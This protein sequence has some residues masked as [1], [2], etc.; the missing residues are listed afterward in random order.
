MLIR[1]M[2]RDIGKNKVQFAAIFLMM[3][4][5][6]FLFS[7]ISGEWNGMQSHFERYIEEQNLAD[8]WAYGESFTEQD[9]QKL[10]EDRR[11]HNIEG[12]MLLPMVPSGSEGVSLDC[13]ITEDNKISQMYV[14]Q[15]SSFDSA[16]EGIWLDELFAGENDYKHGD[17]I[18]LQ[19]KGMNIKGKILGLVY[20]PEY[21]YGASE[22]AMMP[23]HKNS[24]FAFISPGLLPPKIPLFYNQ[25]AVDTDGTMDKDLVSDV[26][27]RE[28]ITEVLARDHPSV[29]M[30]RDEIQQHRVIGTAFSIAFLFIAVMIATTTMHRV[31][32]NQKVQTGILKALGFR[33]GKLMRHYLSHNGVIC[34]LGAFTGYMLGYRVLPPLISAFLMEMYVLP[35]WGGYL[36]AAYL[37][38]PAGCTLLCILISLY[39]CRGYLNKNTAETL[40]TEEYSQKGMYL[41]RPF[42]V[43]DFAGR[44]NV[45]DIMRNRLRS[46]MTLCG[47]LGCTALLFCAFALYDTFGNLPEWMFHK[48]QSYEC[49]ITELPNKEGQKELL[50]L[51]DGEYM[52]EGAAVIEKDSKEEEASLTVLESTKYVKLAESLSQFTKL[53]N[54]AALS[55]KTAE[56]LGVKKGDYITWKPKGEEALRRTKIEVIIRTPM[57]QG[58]VIM[59]KDYDKAGGQYSPTAI[60][61]REPERGFGDYDSLCSISRRKDLTKSLD[62]MM[63]GMIT[64][65]MLLVTGA[66]ILG[67][68]MLYNLG[69]LSYL[70]RYREFAT[71]KVL[72]FRD[73]KV[74]KVMVQQNV[75]LS[76]AGI[77]LGIPAGY[78]LMFYMM[79]TLPDT[80]DVPVFI[81]FMSWIISIA[82]T[83]FLS[84]GVSRIVSRKIPYI[85]MAEALKARE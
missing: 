47:V 84:W 45:R 62:A 85:N 39:I 31:L 30:I 49:K 82:G 57:N 41:P 58:I 25:L 26:L 29:S 37:L 27:G 52:M 17:Y 67:S 12:R 19:Y 66:V 20:S 43:L 10:R 53:K 23:D 61:G 8:R 46:L 40:Y 51:T 3:F 34:F 14:V 72:G 65:V 5:G 59:R 54:G 78:G 64:M 55:K 79:S 22:D 18:D 71:M 1:K 9:I 80:M 68:V 83:L 48:Q 44:W 7:G 77:I 11:V 15:G 38:L 6:C 42:E 13:Y 2:V 81:R 63:G 56:K 21:I 76:A 69:V 16:R 28:D 24:G 70:E 73:S 35:Q 60:V 50:A 74:R 33:R 4:F 75:W 32:K 36:P